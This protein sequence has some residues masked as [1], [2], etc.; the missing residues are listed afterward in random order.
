METKLTA[1]G[2]Q[3]KH[4]R[5]DNEAS[6]LLKSYLHDKKITFQLVP[7]YNHRRNVANIAI[8][9]LKDHLIARMSSTDK[10]FPMHLWDTFLPQVVITINM[11]R[12]SRINSKLSASTHIDG[13]YSYNRDPMAPPGIIIIAQET[14]NRRRTWTPHGQDGWYISPAIVWLLRP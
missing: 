7:Q 13:Q 14:Q 5:L 2:R 12:T 3:P 6:Q 10:A 8:R 4:M 9:S 1:R 11:L